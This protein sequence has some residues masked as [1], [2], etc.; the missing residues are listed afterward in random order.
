MK[1]VL[2]LLILMVVSITL[3]SIPIEYDVFHIEAPIEGKL[4]HGFTYK[5]NSSIVAMIDD[6]ISL[7]GSIAPKTGLDMFNSNPQMLAYYD[8]YTNTR[9][10]VTAYFTLYP[11]TL[12]YSGGT[13]SVPYSLVFQKTAGISKV[14]LLTQT[15]STGGS[16]GIAT[17]PLMEEVAVLSTSGAGPRWYAVSMKIVF[18]SIG[19]LGSGIPEGTYSGSIVARIETN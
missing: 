7:N 2:T 18:D 11:L 13:F 3:Y 4:Y 8:I 10:Q 16:A 14:N 1:R 19:N 9:S 15:V 5:N 12:A 6:L 17:I